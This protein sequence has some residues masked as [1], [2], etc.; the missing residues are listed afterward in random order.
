MF[1]DAFADFEGQV[2]TA[3]GGVALLEIFDD[4]KRV[5]I[6]V[7]NESMLAHGGVERF[8]ASVAEGR[9]ADVMDQG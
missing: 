1:D 8:F 2:Q 9:M 7:E 6:V 5:E 4:A 3:E